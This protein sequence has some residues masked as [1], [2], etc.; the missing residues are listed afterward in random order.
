MGRFLA[1]RDSFLVATRRLKFL[2]SY[3]TITDIERTTE[4]MLNA[5]EVEG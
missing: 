3:S 1:T 2:S 5:I 4:V